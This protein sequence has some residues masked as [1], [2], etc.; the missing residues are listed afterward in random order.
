MQGCSSIHVTYQI[1]WTLRKPLR[2]SFHS[3]GWLLISIETLWVNVEGVE[4][5]EKLFYPLIH[6]SQIIFEVYSNTQIPYSS[7]RHF[8]L[9]QIILF[10][11][12][13][14]SFKIY[15]PKWKF[16]EEDLYV[17][18]YWSLKSL[19]TFVQWSW[20]ILMKEERIL[21][22]YEN[23]RLYN[24]IR[25]LSLNQPDFLN[26]TIFSNISHKSQNNNKEFYVFWGIY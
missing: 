7:L 21:W 25:W 14:L 17:K 24:K 11:L 3:I 16:V 22:H 20:M 18:D 6:S 19:F 9:N 8:S 5:F 13:L 10:L 1:L 15:P 26:W 12:I 4:V 23:K 2:L